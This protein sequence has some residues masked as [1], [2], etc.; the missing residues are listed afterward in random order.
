MVLCNLRAVV[1]IASEFRYH[2]AAFEDLVYGRIAVGL[3]LHRRVTAEKIGQREKDADDQHRHDEQV[4]PSR[5]LIHL[6]S[7]ENRHRFQGAGQ[8]SEDSDFNWI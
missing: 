2:H 5:I 1:K 3:H 7:P 4:F 6:S 8:V